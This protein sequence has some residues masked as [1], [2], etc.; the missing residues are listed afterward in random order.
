MSQ[1]EKTQQAFESQQLHIH[2]LPPSNFKEKI[3]IAS[4]HAFK[5]L[6]SKPCMGNLLSIPGH[7]SSLPDTIQRLHA[8]TRSNGQQPGMRF[9]R[10]CCPTQFAMTLHAAQA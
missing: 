7:Q 10:V 3:G 9:H 1:R 4:K 8:R 5:V 2:L 6:A